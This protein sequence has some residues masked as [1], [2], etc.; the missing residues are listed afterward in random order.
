MEFD[1]AALPVRWLRAA[2]VRD[3]SPHASAERW[4]D[5]L[6]QAGFLVDVPPAVDD[7]D[8][9]A[10]I[11]GV[12]QLLGELEAAEDVVAGLQTRFWDIQWKGFRDLPFS[13]IALMLVVPG[14]IASLLATFPEL[15]GGH[16][17]ELLALSTLPYFSVVIVKN[18]DRIRL[19][20]SRDLR[21]RR[22]RAARLHRD[23]TRDALARGVA[24]TL[25][26]SF[27]ARGGPGLIACAADHEWLERAARAA[28]K[29]DD[30]N[31]LESI[32]EEQQRIE[33]A[34]RTALRTPPEHWTAAGMETDRAR[35]STAASHAHAATTDAPPAGLP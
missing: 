10:W 30:N 7:D 2:P 27:V 31:L 24:A 32:I 16:L 29:T 34:T 14:V 4:R 15:F 20:V 8:P 33:T 19:I 6:L 13:L 5:M 9:R 21:D 3:P 22:L 28:R 1:H 26:R 12:Q 25:E 35:W 17:V 18:L 11:A 23:R